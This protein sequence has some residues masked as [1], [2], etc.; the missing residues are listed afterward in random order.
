MILITL[1]A[2]KLDAINWGTLEMG[3]GDDDKCN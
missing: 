2:P 1:I 3:L